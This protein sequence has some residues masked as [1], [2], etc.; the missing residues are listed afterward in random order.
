MTFTEIKRMLTIL[1]ERDSVQ[2]KRVNDIF[3]MSISQQF[4]HYH[5]DY[6][7]TTT[8]ADEHVEALEKLQL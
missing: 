6:L 5:Q 8:I 3:L 2:N 1:S 7:D 4:D